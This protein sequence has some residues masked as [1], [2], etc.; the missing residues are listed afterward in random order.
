[1]IALSEM[2]LNKLTLSNNLDNLSDEERAI[3]FS[4]LKEYQDNG[5]SELYNEILKSD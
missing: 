3:A 4:I 2:D 5:D 1:M